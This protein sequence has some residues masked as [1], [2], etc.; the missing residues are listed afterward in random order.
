V[1]ED[2]FAGCAAKSIAVTIVKRIPSERI[3]AS[4]ALRR[5]L[6]RDTVNFGDWNIHE[7]GVPPWV[8]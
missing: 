7:H 6:Q 3:L 5:M 2:L 4:P 8:R 1:P